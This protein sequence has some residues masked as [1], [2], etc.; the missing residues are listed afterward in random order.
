MALADWR[1]A[2]RRLWREIRTLRLAGRDPRTPWYAKVVALGVVAYA[3]SPLDLIPDVIPI[4]GYLD[5]LVLV[6]LGLILAL[7][8]IP[9]AVLA[10]ARAR[11]AGASSASVISRID[12]V[13]A[14]VRP[15][16]LSRKTIT[17][18]GGFGGLVIGLGIVFLFANPAPAKLPTPP[19]A[20][21]AAGTAANQV[22]TPTA[23]NE[24]T[25]LQSKT[26]NGRELG[27]FRGM[28]MDDAIR[29]VERRITGKSG[30]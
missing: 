15:V 16:G 14:G 2:A 4:L 13:E 12:G 28:T 21:A 29:M 6:P 1:C 7:R 18:A 17:A 23:V 26:T 30:L 27:L 22:V 25:N 19:T 8:L 24:K 5:D 20:A 11:Q 10:D 3:L 9:P